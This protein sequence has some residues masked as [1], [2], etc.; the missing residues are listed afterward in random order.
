MKN[1][2]AFI[3]EKKKEEN[4][5]SLVQAKIKPSLKE[6]AQKVLDESNTSWNTF[7]EAAIEQLLSENNK[8]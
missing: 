7:L 1:L 5:T 4:K 6:K 3:N 2:T 8:K